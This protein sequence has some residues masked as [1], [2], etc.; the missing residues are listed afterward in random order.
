MLP[1]MQPKINNYADYVLLSKVA[2]ERREQQDIVLMKKVESFQ[3]SNILLESILFH[4][5]T[6]ASKKKFTVLQ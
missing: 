4:S 5:Q 2:Q 3:V 1:L 6:E